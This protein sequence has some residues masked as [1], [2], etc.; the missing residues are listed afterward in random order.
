MKDY[1]SDVYGE[2]W[3]RAPEKYN[4]DRFYYMVSSKGR[5]KKM[6]AESIVECKNEQLL[7]RLNGH[8]TRLPYVVMETFVGKRPA[9]QYV[10]HR[11]GN[12]LNNSLDN[13]YYSRPRN[14]GMAKL[15]EKKVFEARQAYDNGK[16]TT[17][18]LARKYNVSY[19]TMYDALKRRT[20]RE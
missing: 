20:W 7:V 5:I 10:L 18:E 14:T 9:G 16:L 12:R 17:G 8:V 6:P 3:K 11:D 4:T 1:E 2:E 13:L 19:P 15:T